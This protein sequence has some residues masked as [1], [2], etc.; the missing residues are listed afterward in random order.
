MQQIS[1]KLLFRLMGFAIGLALVVWAVVLAGQ[2]IDPGILTLQNAPGILAIAVLVVGNLLVTAALFWIITRCFDADPPV[3]LPQMTR[4]IC[5]SA[6]INYL[7]LGWPGPVARSAYLKLRHNMPV[8]QSV[9]VLAIVMALSG[10]LMLVLVAMLLV[11]SKLLASG[12][13]IVS[14]LALMAGAGAVA[15]AVL[16]RPCT[17]AWSWAPLKALD[18]I[19][20]AVRLWLAFAVLGQ[21]LTPLQALTLAAVDTVVSMLSL[22]PSGLGVSEWVLGYL[23][24]GMGAAASPAAAVAKLLDRSVNVLVVIVAGLVA[25]RGLPLTSPVDQ[26][27]VS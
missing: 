1:S 10:L 13:A 6:L 7:P 12:I 2:Q 21:S 4:I 24:Q 19:L 9:T 18:V 8:R 27:R 17:A 26:P 25:L 15:R 16:K 23:A 22:T 11:P 20:G 14:M 5:A 3:T